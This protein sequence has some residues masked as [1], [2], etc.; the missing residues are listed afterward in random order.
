MDRWQVVL[1]DDG[2]GPTV[3]EYVAGRWVDRKQRLDAVD[4]VGIVDALNLPGNTRSLAEM[5]D[6]PAEGCSFCGSPGHSLAGGVTIRK[7]YSVRCERCLERLTG[8]CPEHV[9][10]L[11]REH[12]RGCQ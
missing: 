11:V 1:Y 7:V 9:S 6:D 2:R 8:D 5:L 4:A 3:Q 10:H 12:V